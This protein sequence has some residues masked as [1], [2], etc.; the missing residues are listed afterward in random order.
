MQTVN[1]PATDEFTGQSPKTKHE[2]IASGQ[3]LS[4]YTPMGRVKATGELISWAPGASDGS[5]KALFLTAF[6]IDTSAG[7]KTHAVIYDCMIN[8]EFINW[9][10][11]TDIQKAAAFDMTEIKQQL[12]R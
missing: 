5:E 1:I 12:P 6:A 2:T 3:T 7:E 8:P 4:K 9:P 10:T 11:A